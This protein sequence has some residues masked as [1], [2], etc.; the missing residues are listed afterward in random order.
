M[1]LHNIEIAIWN[2]HLNLV[3]IGLN[4]PHQVFLLPLQHLLL[5]KLSLLIVL[6]PLL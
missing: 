2:D 1:L 5:K 6:I 3:I 4:L